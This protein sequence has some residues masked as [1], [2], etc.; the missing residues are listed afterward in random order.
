M[1]E[2]RESD[3]NFRPQMQLSQCVGL[4]KAE[5]ARYGVALDQVGRRAILSH[6]VPRTEMLSWEKSR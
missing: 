3:G 1:T 5:V 6:R 2:F 4:Q